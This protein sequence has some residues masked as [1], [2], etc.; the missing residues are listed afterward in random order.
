VDEERLEIEQRALWEPS[1]RGAWSGG[2]RKNVNSGA[3]R[4]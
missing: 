4:T 1:L 2:V 3:G